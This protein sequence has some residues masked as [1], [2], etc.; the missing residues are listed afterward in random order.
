MEKEEHSGFHSQDG[1]RGCK[2][3]G[4]LH[5]PRT[6]VSWSAGIDADGRIILFFMFGIGVKLEVTQNTK[7]PATRP[8][9]MKW[10]IEG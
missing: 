1:F 4:H 7:H 9:T 6:Q 8:G 5:L 3:R 2:A 10:E